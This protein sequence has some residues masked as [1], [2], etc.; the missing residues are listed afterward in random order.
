MKP[1][2][3]IEIQDMLIAWYW[4][5]GGISGAIRA[6]GDRLLELRAAEAAAKV[7]DEGVDAMWSAWHERGKLG[8]AAQM[9]AAAEALAKRWGMTDKPGPCVWAPGTDGHDEWSTSCGA[10]ERWRYPFCRNCGKPVEVT[11]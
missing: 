1:V 7:T 6:A 4:G 10:S 9:R 2:T 11:R 8:Q 5:V 3:D